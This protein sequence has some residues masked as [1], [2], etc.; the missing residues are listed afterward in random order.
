MTH[1]DSAFLPPI[2]DSFELLMKAC[3][4]LWVG[5]VKVSCFSYLVGGIVQLPWLWVTLSNYCKH[6]FINVAVPH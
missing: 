1:L 2:E 4:A 6:A 3:T 5:L